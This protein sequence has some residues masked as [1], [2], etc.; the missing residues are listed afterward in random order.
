MQFTI[1]RSNDERVDFDESRLILSGDA[2]DLYF[3]WRALD[4]MID[5]KE[6]PPEI[7][8]ACVLPIH[9]DQDVEKCKAEFQQRYE[10][11]ILRQ[12]EEIKANRAKNG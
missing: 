1:I 6:N 4:R 2:F 12:A 8:R 10:N 11:H 7:G 3:L 5:D 9:T